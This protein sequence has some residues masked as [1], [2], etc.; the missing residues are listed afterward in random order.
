MALSAFCQ[1]SACV[2]KLEMEFGLDIKLI[3]LI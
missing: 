3:A 1:E 2:C